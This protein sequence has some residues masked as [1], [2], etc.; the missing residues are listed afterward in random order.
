MAALPQGQPEGGVDLGHASGNSPPMS[1]DGTS[2]PEPDQRFAGILTGSTKLAGISGWPVSH[3]RSPRLH[4]FWLRRHNIDGAYVP[5]PIRPGDFPVAVRGL[6]AAGFRGLNVTQP[7]KLVAFEVC[8]VVDE[9]ARRAGVVNTI[10]F[11]DDAIRGSNTDGSGFVAHLRA[12]GV[13]PAG[14]PVLLLGAGG[15]ARAV[16]AALLDAGASVSVA[17]R[18]RERAEALAGALP[19]LAVTA[20]ERRNDALADHA[21]LV[22]AT[23]LG[24]KGNPPLEIDLGRAST[25]LAVADIVYVP[26]ETP[27]LAAARARGMRAVD[28]LGMLLHQ[29]GFGFAAWFGVTPTV[30]EELRRFVAGDLM[31]EAAPP[32]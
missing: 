3:S 13:E 28:G 20:W 1:N 10:I 30:D 7:H 25:D 6:R 5:L 15:G 22:N 23:S 18:N 14:K 9:T 16:A 4:G 11:S 31:P 26:L 12:S 21:V 2:P 19:G 24:M 17:N 32:A 29:A 8:D 27:L